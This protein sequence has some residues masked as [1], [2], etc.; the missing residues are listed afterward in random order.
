TRYLVDRG[1]AVNDGTP[2]GESVLDMAK[3]FSGPELQRYIAAK[4][5][6]S[7]NDVK[8]QIDVVNDGERGL[9]RFW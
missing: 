2:N 1:A 5:G 7:S 6:F 9:F 4:G 3:R 8:R